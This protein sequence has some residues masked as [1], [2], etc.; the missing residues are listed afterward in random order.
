[1]MKYLRLGGAIVLLIIAIFYIE[2]DSGT[3]YSNQ[4]SIENSGQIENYQQA[5]AVFWRELYPQGRTLYCGDEFTASARSGFNVEHV[6][7]M[8]WVTNSLNC[9]T[10]NQCRDR[11]DLF[12][13]IEADLHN[14]FPTRTET[15]QARSS[16][17]F[18]E[19]NGESRPFGQTCDFEVSEGQR[20]AEPREEV[21]GDV[22][23]AMFYMAYHYKEH[24]LQ[25]FARQARLLLEWHKSDPPIAIDK[26]RNDAIQSI[27]GNR[28]PFVDNPEQLEDLVSQGY[29]F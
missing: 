6:F 4:N 9:G 16:F 11:S 26:S 20:L 3:D 12:N 28:N 25:L 19:I 23:R 8:S 15:N 7:P 14:L 10:R 17:A 21:R 5:R 24:G 1:M 27:Q 18:A 13:Q 2:D 22:A 29:F